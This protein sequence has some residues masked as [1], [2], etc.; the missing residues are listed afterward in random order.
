MA[1]N[2]TKSLI[3]LLLALLTGGSEVLNPLFSMDDVR[4]SLLTENLTDLD[5]VEESSES[6]Q[7]A[8]LDS[9]TC[10][11][12]P[13]THEVCDEVIHQFDWLFLHEHSARAPPRD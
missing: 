2:S 9:V 13:K 8:S 1:R 4:P 7:V 10:S 6:D 3:L 5:D 12:K 11:R